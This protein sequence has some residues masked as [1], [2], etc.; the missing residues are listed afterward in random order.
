MQEVSPTLQRGSGV[1]EAEELQCH[2]W[3]ANTKKRPQRIKLQCYKSKHCVKK[4]QIGH[5]TSNFITLL[6][7]RKCFWQ[8]IWCLVVLYGQPLFTTPAVAFYSA[9]LST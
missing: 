8:Y 6:Y 4:H 5:I 9:G 7:S 2:V 1:P 3:A